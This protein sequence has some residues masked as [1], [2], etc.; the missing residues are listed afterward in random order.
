MR[1]P[2]PAA[3]TT[4]RL[5]RAAIRILHART[6]AAVL[7]RFPLQ[8]KGDSPRGNGGIKADAHFLIIFTCDSAGLEEGQARLAKDSDHLAG[9][10][11][12]TGGLFST[13]LAEEDEFDRR[14]TLWRGAL[15]G[16]RPLAAV[17][18]ALLGEHSP[19]ALPPHPPLTPP[20]PPQPP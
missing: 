7:M 12:D 11:E 1:V 18:R 8:R 13:L 5:E 3:S 14:R 20:P 6:N 19:P 9:F 4:V 17:V 2:S 15:L 16:A 10:E